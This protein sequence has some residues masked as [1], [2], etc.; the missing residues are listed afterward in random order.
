M[1]SERSKT[2]QAFS[3]VELVFVTAIVGIA[4]AIVLPH[5][6]N[7]VQNYQLTLAA[8]RIASDLAWAQSYANSSSASVTVTFRADGKYMLGGVADPDHP[9]AGYAVDLTADPYHVK[10]V[11]SDP[12][13]TT[14]VITFNGFGV[15]AQGG[16]VIV[17]A[18]GVQR[19]VTVSAS[20]GQITVQ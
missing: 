16:S 15:S 7:S 19:T 17:A 9:D 6:S 18:G 14:S 8:R 12:S 10:L 4:C 3:L 2:V 1:P 13:L 5:W 20:T 11:L